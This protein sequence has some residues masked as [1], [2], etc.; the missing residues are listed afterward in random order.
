MSDMPDFDSMTPEEITE[1]MESLAV[2]QGATEGLTTAASMEIDEV[3]EADARL[4]G[5]GDYKPYGMSDEDWEKMQ[6]REAE[7][8]AAKLA[9][10]AQSTPAPQAVAPPEP[11]PI[12]EPVA[13][14]PVASDDGT[15]DF[16][17]MTPEQMMEWMESLAV[18]QGATEGITTSA[19]MEI[20]EVD[21]T[22][23]RLEGMGE[24]KPYAMSDEDWAKMQ[25]REAEE[26]AAKLASQ[27]SSTPVVEEAE[28]EYDEEYSYED[29]DEYEEYDDDEEYFEYQDDS[30]EFVIGN[31]DDSE[32]LVRADMSALGFLGDDEDKEESDQFSAIDFANLMPEETFEEEEEATANP[33][34]WLASLSGTEEEVTPDI[35][36]S[37]EDLGDLTGLGNEEPIGDPMNWLASLSEAPSSDDNAIDFSALSANVMDDDTADE[38][39]LEW[40]ESLA[41]NQGAPE[42]ELITDASLNIPMPDNILDD[43]PGYEEF[44]F[45]DATGI[46]Q[47]SDSMPAILDL[48]ED[49]EELVLDDPESWLDNLASGVADNELPDDIFEGEAFATSERAD[50]GQFDDLANNVKSQ[51]DAGKLGD[52]PDDINKFFESAFARASTRDDVPD[53]IDMDED[54]PE[55]EETLSELPVPAEIPDWLQDSMATMPSELEDDEPEEQ[56]TATAEMMVADLGLDEDIENVE[57]PDWLQ[58]GAEQDTGAIDLDIFDADEEAFDEE[59]FELNIA[60]MTE[61]QDTWVEAFSAEDTGELAA[62]YDDAITTFEGDSEPIV[63]QVE[64]A[65]IVLEFADLPIERNLAEGTAQNVPAWISG[66]DIGQSVEVEAVQDDNMD[67]LNEDVSTDDEIDMPDWLKDTVDDSVTDG[68]DL[69]DWLA[70]EED[71]SEDDI[72]DWLRE[73]MDEEEDVSDVFA[74]EEAVVEAPAPST[75][76]PVPVAQSPAPMT[77]SADKIDAVAYLRSAKEKFNAKDIDGAMLD[78][79]QVIRSN[80]A[81]SQ[82][83]KELQRIVEEKDY[84]RNPSVNRVLGDVLMRQGKLQQALDIYRKALNML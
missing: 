67:W 26:K 30:E 75:P 54:E 80:K 35:G 79:E 77:V 74:L 61:T 10:Q 65:D 78:Y 6:A 66:S 43:G 2:R 68:E 38:G 52:S 24:Y 31:L 46:V 41:A 55:S 32:E 40:M 56:K 12:P 42:D 27:T 7:E 71:I 63:A 34:D 53:Y 48:G 29:D 44:S 33:M 17:S 1:W 62:W 25:A 36:L 22:D 5:M 20:D 82:V 60:D 14:D 76:L 39:S 9:N 3:D 72:P 45:E 73:T 70:G 83:E 13:E 4:E 81:L 16:D 84:K 51:M 69:P 15:P 18:R 8:K 58:S 64:S 11:D 57:I 49:E 50:S 47:D 28:E 21:E 23:A 37:M 59:V 19:S